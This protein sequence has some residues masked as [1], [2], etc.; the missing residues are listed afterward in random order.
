[1][2]ID[3][4][5]LPPIDLTPQPVDD[6]FA[7]IGNGGFW[8]RFGIIAAGIFLVITGTVIAV[9]GTRAVKQVGQLAVGVASKVVTKGAV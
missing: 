1:M 4:G 2:T 7:V 8:Q 9:S 6:V 3:T 5:I